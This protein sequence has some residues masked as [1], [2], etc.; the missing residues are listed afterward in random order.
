MTDFLKR[1]VQIL[2]VDNDVTAAASQ[3]G[4]LRTAGYDASAAVGF[5]AASR[6]L[7]ERPPHLLITP[8][9]LGAFNGVHLV[10]RGRAQKPEVLALIIGD[11]VDEGRE[12]A[13]Q[14]GASFACK[15]QTR[16]Q[17]LDLVRDVLVPGKREA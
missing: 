7:E 14:S 9:R 17:L 16:D 8:L 12:E 15:P 5:Q 13:Q 10:F 1:A 6:R 11:R 3:V 2:V 4:W